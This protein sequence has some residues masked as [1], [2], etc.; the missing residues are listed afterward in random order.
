MEV[1]E[2]VGLLLPVRQDLVGRDGDRL[3]LLPIARV[4]A[5]LVGAEVGLVEDLVA[6][7]AECGDVGGEDEGLCLH[8]AHRAD[9]NDGL[10][11]AAGQRDDARAAA[12]GAARVEGVYRLDLVGAKAER[13]AAAARGDQVYFEGCSGLVAGEVFDGVADLDERMLHKAALGDLH[14]HAAVLDRAQQEGG[15]EPVHAD[16][17]EDDRVVGGDGEVLA[18]GHEFQ[19][20]VARHVVVHV[21]EDVAGDL[22]LGEGEQL[23]LHLLGLPA[24]RGGV[25][26]RERGNPVGVDVLG[27]LHQLRK[28]AEGVAR[29]F[30]LRGVGLEQDGLVG[31]NDDG[32][33]GSKGHDSPTSRAAHGRPWEGLEGA[34]R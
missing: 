32:V 2:G 26:E 30:E 17:G 33:F 21:G 10:A 24:E 11:G 6:P 27:R 16:F 31:L 13:S 28:A 25:P 9:A 12:L 18:I 7:L 20:T 8:L 22:I 23:S 14:L 1:G 4:L 29:L 3:D 19:P 15:D 5:D 34:A